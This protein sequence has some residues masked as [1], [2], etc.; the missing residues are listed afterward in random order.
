MGLAKSGK[1]LK[2]YVKRLRTRAARQTL[3]QTLRT[4]LGEAGD[5]LRSDVKTLRAIVQCPGDAAVP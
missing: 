3:P 5:A 1:R 4:E 2:K